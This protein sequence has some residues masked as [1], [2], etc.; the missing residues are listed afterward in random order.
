MNDNKN[1][2][3]P[4][5][6]IDARIA[7]LS[8]EK[9]ALLLKRLSRGS[10]DPGGRQVLR[11]RSGERSFELSFA[12]QRLWFLEQWEGGSA[13]YNITRAWWLQGLLEVER[14]RGALAQLVA[15]HESLRTALVSAQG[16]PRQQVL[17][18]LAVDLPLVDLRALPADQ[19]RAQALAQAQSLARQ[20]FNL[21]QAPLLRLTL[22]R[23]TESTHL[24]V[25]VMHHIISDGW[26]MGV[27]CRELAALYAGT[28]GQLPALPVQYPDYAQS[29]RAELQGAA[30]E[31]QLAYW[32]T[33]LAGLT[34]LALPTDRLRPPAQSY[35]GAHQSLTLSAEL[36]AAL[37]QLS[38][39]ERVTLYMLLLAAF[40][41][42]LARY[43]GQEDIA[44]GS[45]IAGRTRIEFE[46]LIGFFV[47]TLVLRTDL[48]GN[49]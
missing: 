11:A 3:S 45:P 33:K 19:A 37:K 10:G 32:R 34:T 29:Q 28:G 44:V 30:L 27:F 14:L 12:Q 42:L 20:G 4:G 36:S 41:V 49:P 31:R 25:L 39:R 23:V 16:Q 38:Q 35:R 2:L 6:D 1:L 21:E 18:D 24:L 26:S 13:L 5:T 7:E 9:R 15:R 22:L 47:N 43:S 17:A 8:P 40:Q 46:G 48:S